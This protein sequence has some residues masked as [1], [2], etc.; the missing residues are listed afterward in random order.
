MDFLCILIGYLLLL[1]ILCVFSI[2]PNADYYWY[3]KI[4]KQERVEWATY[5]SDKDFVDYYRN[6]SAELFTS[7]ENII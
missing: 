6:D 1:I 4:A 3:D 2:Y 5:V 7:V